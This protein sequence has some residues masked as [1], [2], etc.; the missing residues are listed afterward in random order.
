MKT[1]QFNY[2]DILKHQ[3]E[4]RSAKNSSYSLRAFARDLDLN[5][6]R[7]SEILS[8]K[9]GLSLSAANL[10][11]DKLGLN[12]EEKEF[13]L[14]SVNAQHS[15]SLKVKDQALAT[16][17]EKLTPEKKIKQLEQQEIEQA[18]NWY[19]TAILE[20]TELKDCE[21]TVEWFAKKLKLKK[22]IIKNALERLEKIG[23][24]KMEDGIYKSSYIESETTFDVPSSTIRKYHEEVLK[25]AEQSLLTDS[26]LEREFLN[27][28]LAFSQEQM[29]E[30]KEAIRSFQKD[31]ADKFYP[32]EKAKDS[33]YQLSVHLFRLDSNLEAKEL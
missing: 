28:T 11:A 2:I 21:H 5:P 9:K 32:K 4:L 30:A 27:M 24:L 3:L 14:L 17:T 20:L 15:R 6:S 31:F 13:F 25:K 12:A 23:W 7:L 18:Y 33:V 16:L 22:V 19:H 26:I 8:K 1:K 29:K 10:L